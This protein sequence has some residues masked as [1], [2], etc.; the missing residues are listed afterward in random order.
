[1]VRTVKPYSRVILKRKR[2]ERC[3]VL[4]NPNEIDVSKGKISFESPLGKALLN[5]KTKEEISVKT[6]RGVIKYKIIAID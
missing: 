4:V 6:P 3:F 2:D 1:M 5:R